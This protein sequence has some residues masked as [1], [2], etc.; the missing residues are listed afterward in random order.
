MLRKI[1]GKGRQIPVK[2]DGRT[3]L[4]INDANGSFTAPARPRE[5]SV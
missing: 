2:D 5:A 4:E 3:V 1:Y